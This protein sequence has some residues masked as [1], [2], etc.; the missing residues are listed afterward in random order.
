MQKQLV[1]P[2]EKEGLFLR[3][4]S[5]LA[6]LILNVS[7]HAYKVTDLISF[8]IQSFEGNR[9]LYPKCYCTISDPQGRDCA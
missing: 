2:T 4:Q 1:N 7:L 6:V 3:E 9:I 8:S 5:L